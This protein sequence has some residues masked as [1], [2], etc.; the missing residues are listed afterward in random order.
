M[1]VK[2]LGPGRH[3]DAHGLCLVVRPTGSR[4]WVLRMQF[5]GHRRDFGLG[6]VH[7]V[8]LEQIPISL[9]RNRLR[10]SSWR[11]RQA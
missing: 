9:H 7:D 3:F 5:K 4:S 11:I 6:P 1:K 2:T 10:R 8:S